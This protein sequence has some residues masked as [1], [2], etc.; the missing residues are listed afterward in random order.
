MPQSVLK[1]PTHV[2]PHDLRHSCHWCS[3]L[4]TH[5]ELKGDLSQGSFLRQRPLRSLPT[6]FLPGPVLQS[7]GL[8]DCRWSGGR[9]CS[10]VSVL[11][12]P[13]VGDLRRRP[14]G[15]PAGSGRWGGW[16]DRAGGT[17]VPRDGGDGGI[18]QDQEQRARPGAGQGS[19]GH[20]Q[21]LSGKLPASTLIAAEWNSGRFLR[22]LPGVS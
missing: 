9:A 17:P 14:L 8:Q 3:L 7:R 10:S 5:H 18:K 4:K 16:W 22:S 6:C 13:Q 1:S 21:D 15:S 11:L 20:Q 2:V 19:R 12:C